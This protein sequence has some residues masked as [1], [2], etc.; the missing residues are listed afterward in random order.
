MNDG[1]IMPNRGCGKHCSDC[2]I[3]PKC[4]QVGTAASSQE[5]KGF[6]LGK[7]WTN[8]GIECFNTLFDQVKADH[9]ANPSFVRT[10]IAK[11]C[12]SLQGREGNQE[13]VMF[14]KYYS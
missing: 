2:T 11:D 7:L 8:E 9:K 4:T 10:W 5:D 1:K 3:F 6:E 12:V 14:I 13:N